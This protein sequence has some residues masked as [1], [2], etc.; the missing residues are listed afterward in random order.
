MKAPGKSFCKDISL[1]GLFEMLPDEATAE[2]RFEE[3]RWGEGAA[4]FATL[5]AS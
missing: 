4:R 1:A 3:V 2:A 5:Q